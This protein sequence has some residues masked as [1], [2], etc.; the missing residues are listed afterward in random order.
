MQIYMRKTAHAVIVSDEVI[1]KHKQE[2][3]NI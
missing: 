1:T 3:I 2:K